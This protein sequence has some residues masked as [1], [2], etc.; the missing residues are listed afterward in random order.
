MLSPGVMPSTSETLHLAVLLSLKQIY[1]FATLVLKVCGHTNA[2]LGTWSKMQRL[3]K[4]LGF[5]VFPSRHFPNN[6]TSLKSPYV[7]LIF[8]SRAATGWERIL[9]QW[10]QTNTSILSVGTDS[11]SFILWAKWALH[12]FP[13][14]IYLRKSLFREAVQIFVP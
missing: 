11:H 10:S 7:D 5:W 9:W 4:P 8:S 1:V 12:F 3:K 13:Y 6:L 2:I 14:F